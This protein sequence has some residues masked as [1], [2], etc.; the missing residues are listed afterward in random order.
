MD[1][2]DFMGKLKFILIFAAISIMSGWESASAAQPKGLKN[3]LDNLDRSVCQK[4]N[5]TCKTRSKQPAAK[6][7]KQTQ[8]P[9]TP[10]ENRNKCRNSNNCAAHSR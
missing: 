6:R 9:A 2:R 8:P 7:K 5:A 10:A 4:F 1:H 3:F